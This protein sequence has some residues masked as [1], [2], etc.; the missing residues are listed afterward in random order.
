M[1]SKFLR[2]IKPST[3]CM[4]L[5]WTASAMALGY[6]NETK[7]VNH[8]DYSNYTITYEEDGVIKT[9]LLTDEAL[10]PAHQKA[11][12]K[13]VYSDPTIP[14]IQYGYNYNNYQNRKIDYNY[15]GHQGAPGF[16]GAADDPSYWVDTT[17][18]LSE[19]F[20][21]PNNN[22]MTL[23]L[24]QVNEDWKGKSDH[25]KY[26]G[27][28][29]FRRG[30]KS[31]QLI[32]NFVRVNDDSNPGYLFTINDATNRFFF[33]SKGKARHS[34]TKPFYRLFEQISPVSDTQGGGGK[35][36]DNFIDEMKAGNTFACY[37]DCSSVMSM[38]TK[39]PV[40]GKANPHWFEISQSHENFNLKNLTIFI[41]DRRFEYEL[42]GDN[43][44]D[45]YK[46]PTARFYNEY[47]NSQNE[48]E[49][50]FELMPQMVMYT[51]T[52][53]ATVSEAETRGYFNIHL[54]WQSAF[55]GLAS[56]IPE[57]YYVY[58]T[59]GVHH[60]LLTTIE[61]PTT[62][63]IHDILV[64]QLA[65]PQTFHFIVRAAPIIY[66]DDGSIY[67]D[68]QG[69]PIYTINAESLIR[70]VT[71]PGL[72]PFFSES[73]DCR[74]EF[75][76]PNERNIYKN[77]I[78]VSPTT[79]QD[80]IYIKN[81][82]ER[83]H[84][85]RTDDAGNSVTVADVQFA[86][87]EE[88]SSVN[89]IPE[90]GAYK[91]KNAG[92]G[93]YVVLQNSMLATVTG[94]EE[95]AP[96]LN[97]DYD[98]QSN[99]EG[100]ITALNGDGGDM[101]GTLNSIK[102]SFREVLDDENMPAD[103]L[104]DMFTL[105]VAETGDQD[106][107]V[108]LCVDVPEIE[109]FDDIRNYL[110]ATSGGNAAVNF[111]LAHMVSGSRHY[112]KVD[113]DDSFGFGTTIDNTC[114]WIIGNP[115]SNNVYIYNYI[116]Q[117][118]PETQEIIADS[119]LHKEEPVTQ[120]ILSGYDSAHVP[121]IDRFTASTATNEQSSYYTYSLVQDSNNDKHSNALKVRVYK[122][123]NDLDYHAYTREE[124]MEQDLDRSLKSGCLTYVTF[125]AMNE[126]LINLN[127]YSVYCINSSNAVNKVGKAENVNNNGTYHLLGSSDT[128]QGYLNEDQGI[129][130]VG[131][132]GGDV[133]IL[134]KD[135]T[136]STTSKYVP[137]I[138]TIYDPATF[139][140]NSYGCN[141]QQQSFPK[142]T[143]SA[144]N[145]VMSMPFQGAYGNS[146][147]YSTR[148]TITPN[149]PKNSAINDVYYY[150]VWRFCETNTAHNPTTTLLNDLN[151]V[152]NGESFTGG[153]WSCDYNVLH[154]TG[155]GKSK[156]Y[157]TDQYVDMAR[158]EGK[159]KK[160]IYYVRMYASKEA[161][162][163]DHAP[164]R[165]GGASTEDGRDIFIAEASCTVRYTANVPTSIDEIN[166]EDYKATVT[167]YNL[168]GVASATPY[169]GINIVVTRYNNGKTISEKKILHP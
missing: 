124:I 101:I 109:N 56:D 108:F 47:G 164:C 168:M 70:T 44:S 117:Y 74:S 29:Y 40:T 120:G 58:A 72:S 59:D 75:D 93:N 49:E 53:D 85:V 18:D 116:V 100:I 138:E 30:I 64:P 113:G 65:D 36:T 153:T 42:Q 63:T 19:F 141:R 98:M 86:L 137:A 90:P 119:E 112:L 3:V 92:T 28:E 158:P 84:V 159:E 87:D 94:T 50:I 152:T 133:T 166:V 57:H 128:S 9:A 114:K 160:V 136:N 169:D 41:P 76:I 67:C 68:D 10:T 79:T 115:L 130:E 102:E 129:V 66:N 157:V 149:L 82:P 145:T 83:Y 118:Y 148:L 78:T 142:V 144:G 54:K 104:N 27:D 154:N 4:F 147:G 110:I 6:H 97:F 146:M 55:H 88:D 62:D 96:E 143:V 131:E 43:K 13:A 121:I 81:N 7:W 38:T 26:A 167:Y 139:T 22:G 23:L 162:E 105:R 31:I 35:T 48:G 125:N 126:P 12:L 34:Y 51:V 8:F 91:F 45:T 73:S 80:Y 21:N 52:L 17:P 140:V 161:A 135:A 2:H 11:L 151:S 14:G 24:V 165:V 32:P 16:Q 5:L 61:Q 123:T 25:D 39:D 111:Y 77:N 69:L 103:F 134:V 106:G 122:T 60:Q 163:A 156:V 107:S 33:L 15:F 1:Y 71:V 37:H 89:S 20:P 127:D 132:E 155:P 150:R 95:D 99:G 46:D